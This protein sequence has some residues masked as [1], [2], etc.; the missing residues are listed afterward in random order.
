MHVYVE[1]GHLNLKVVKFEYGRRSKGSRNH[2]C[3]FTVDL[4]LQAKIFIVINTYIEGKIKT[5]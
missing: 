2:K 5:S 1:G 3:S 4:Y